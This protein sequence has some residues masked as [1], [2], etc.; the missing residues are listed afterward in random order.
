MVYNREQKLTIVVSSCDRYS[1]LWETFFTVFKKQWENCPCRIILNTES[2]S[3]SFDGLKIDC[4]KLYDSPK[5]AEKDEW[6]GRLLKTLNH[7]KTPYVML[8]LEDFYLASK[9]NNDAVSDMLDRIDGIKNF[10]CLYLMSLFTQ[11]PSYYDKKSGFFKLHKYIFYKV[12]ATAGLWKTDYIKS[13][14]KSGQNAW[15]FELYATEKAYKDREKFYCLTQSE[16]DRAFRKRQP[17]SIPKNIVKPIDFDFSAQIAKGKWTTQAVKLLKELG[18]EV[19]F[20]KRGITEFTE[21]D[22]QENKNYYIKRFRLAHGENRFI[23]G[24]IFYVNHYILG[25]FK[26]SD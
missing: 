16:A 2:K 22:N 8:I 19:D 5:D 25:K 6:S 9:V 23:Y 4:L 7:V 24:L 12:N 26:K 15:Q 13:L 18:I 3:Y 14:L 21:F 1:D 11:A 10:G 20:N 17:K